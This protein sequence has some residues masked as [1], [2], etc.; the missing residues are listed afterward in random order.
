MGEAEAETV[1][2]QR[3]IRVEVAAEEIG[4]ATSEPP[5]ARRAAHSEEQ[6]IAVRHRGPAVLEA[7][8]VWD[9]GAVACAVAVVVAGNNTSG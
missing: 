8:P 2:H 5:M 4:L 3:E 6:E 1:E 7:R 9:H